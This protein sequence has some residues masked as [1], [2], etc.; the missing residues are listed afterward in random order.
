M[1]IVRAPAKVNL[2]LEVL[3]RRPD[4]FHS[5][6]SFMVPVGLFDWIEFAPSERSSLHCTDPALA[7]GNLVERA[8]SLAGVSQPLAISIEKMIP[9][10]GGLGGGSSDAAATLRAVMDGA[11]NAPPRLDWPAI[12]RQLGSDVPFFLAGTGALVEGTGERVTPVGR[13]PP[14]WTVIVRPAAAVATAQAYRLLDE[15]REREPAPS[16]SRADSRSLA[17]VDAL[18]RGE[19]ATLVDLLDNDFHKPV[20]GAY[21]AIARAHAALL[22]AGADRALLSGSG[23][24]VFSLHPDE[25]SARAIA[26]RLDGTDCAGQFVAPFYAAPEWR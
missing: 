4:G 7:D 2:T 23:S 21:P 3:A 19:F 20:L 24:C 17:A 22:G 12:A 6:R 8:L 15:H 18:Q 1:P 26:G 25:T 11:F 16:R 13:L 9:V 10:G 14:W 5:L